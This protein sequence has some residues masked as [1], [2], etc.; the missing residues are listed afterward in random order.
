M[1]QNKIDLIPR[2]KEL[3]KRGE[4]II[5][6]LRSK[7]GANLNTI[8][9][10]LISY[11]FQ[12]GSYI[13]FTKENALYNEAFTRAIAKV[14]N[15]LGNYTTLL[16]VGA[17]EATTLANVALKLNIDALKL[18]GFDIS[19]S[20]INCG[21]HYLKEKGVVANLFVADLFN[22]PLGDNT[23]DILYTSHSIEPNGGKEKEALAELYRVTRKYLV[24]LEPTDEFA[25]EEG[26]LRMKKNGYVQNLK[27]HIEELG[28]NLT[29]YQPFEITANPL[30]PTGLYIINKEVASDENKDAVYCCPISKGKLMEYDDHFFSPESLISYPKIMGIPCLCSSYGVLTAKHD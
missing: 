25:D 2:I 13:K 11:D 15:S 8:E 6:F 9:D 26:K 1:I 28:Y 16:E 24:L 5:Q 4:N 19:W 20:R 17:G 12:A 14:L 22:I 21:N 18:M 10:I 30:N 7:S 29:T 23:V 3:Y 27:K